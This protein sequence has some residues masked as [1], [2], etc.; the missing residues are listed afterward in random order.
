MA[1]ALGLLLPTLIAASTDDAEN[2]VELVENESA[3][4]TD[5]LTVTADQVNETGDNGTI[6]LTDEQSLDTATAF[7][8]ES[9]QK[10][11]TLS[12]D[13]ITVAL[14][15]VATDGTAKITL[16]YPPLFAWADGPRLFMENIHIVL[17]GL[18]AAIIIGL[19]VAY[20][21]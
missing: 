17:V 15:D 12:G 13:N 19:T 16:T 3:T 2:T 11:V 20:K 9:Q 21:P 14:D 10:N 18:A 1:L 5:R 4:L 7:L 6:Q 8:N